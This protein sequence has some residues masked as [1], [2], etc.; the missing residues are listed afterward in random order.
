[1]LLV[2]CSSFQRQFLFHPSHHYQENGLTAWRVEGKTIGYRREMHNPE[3]VWL[4]LHGN[5]GQA[6]DRAYAMPCFSEKDAVYVL[7]YPGYGSRDGKP[8][9]ATFDAAAAGAYRILRGT[10][11][12]IPICLVG[13][14]IGSGPACSLASQSPPPD[15]IV[16]VVPFDKLTSVAADHVRFLPVGLFLEAKWDNIR[17]LS[18]Y[19]GPVEVFGAERDT[20]IPINHARKLAASVPSARFH[21]IPGDH[22]GWPQEDRVRIRN[23]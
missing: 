16:L 3:N 10:Y 17:S 7:E 11:P 12:G 9:R 1:M 6:A 18:G 13:E 23:P 2:G 15:K 4:M 21:M 20:V 22:N 19:S 14:S 8:S 5:A